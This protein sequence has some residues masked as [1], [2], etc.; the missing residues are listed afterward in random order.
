MKHVGSFFFPFTLSSSSSWSTYYYL[1]LHHEN[2]NTCISLLFFSWKA[3]WKAE[4]LCVVLIIVMLLCTQDIINEKALIKSL[5]CLDK[6]LWSFSS[7]MLTSLCDDG[8]CVCIDRH[9]MGIF[10][11]V[12]CIYV[13]VCVFLF[14]RILRWW[15]WSRWE[16]W[17]WC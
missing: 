6:M 4:T 11:Y 5:S 13:S 17:W 2:L 14:R 12:T 1:Y 10:I 16:G 3:G 15:W 9:E 7:Y 8:V